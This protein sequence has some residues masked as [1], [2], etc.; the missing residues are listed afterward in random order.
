MFIERS[1]IYQNVL[2]NR[3]IKILFI[4][5]F[6]IIIAMVLGGYQLLLIKDIVSSKTY[7][8]SLPP[9]LQDND[10]EDEMN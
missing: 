4:L 10:S 3:E 2:A 7:G 5:I 8:F 9:G 1:T 6:K